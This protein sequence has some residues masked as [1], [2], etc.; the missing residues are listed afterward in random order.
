MVRS[1]AAEELIPDWTGVEHAP[2]NLIAP[3]GITNPVLTAND[4]TDVS[5]G[6][7]ADPFL[8]YENDQWHMFFEVFNLTSSH[9][10]IGLA[11]SS[12]GFHWNYERIVLSENYHLSYPFILKYDGKYY[13]IPESFGQKSVKLYE[14]VNFPYDWRHFST[15]VSGKDFADP[16]VFYYDNTWWMFVSNPASSNCY[17][18]Y[19][20]QLTNGWTEHPKSPIVR[21][22]KSKARPGGRSFVFDNGRIIRI[23]QKCDI[24][25]GELVRAF[26]VDVLS[27]T[28]YREHEV[29]ESP[30]LTQSWN[31]TDMHQFDPWWNGDH[32]LCAVDAKG[33]GY[34]WS[35]G[36]YVAPRTFTVV[37][38]P[39]GYMPAKLQV[40]NR[41]YLDRVYTL[42]S[43]PPGLALGGEEWI[44]TRNGDKGNT[45]DSFL[46]FTIEQDC[47]VYVAYDRRATFLPSWLANKFVQTS[48]SISVADAAMDRF[49]VFKKSF[50]AGTVSLGGN[51]SSGAAGAGSN[52]VVIVQPYSQ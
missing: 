5:A 40:G 48:L 37:N 3:S 25:Y 19:S 12:D 7:V 9:G 42:T 11:S 28:D 17:L 51:L 47:I 44:M 45:S 20:E 38:S 33:G 8:F 24:V 13:M 43:I 16:T 6:F 34:S 35:I 14:A 31:N 15:L 26:E 22:D 39:S 50:S 4:V 2:F 41:Y 30:I 10:D 36:L 18:Y 21:N 52:Y 1:A 23:A 49:G 46:E 29:S 32:W 27:R